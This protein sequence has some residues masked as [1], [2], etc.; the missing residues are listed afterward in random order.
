MSHQTGYGGHRGSQNPQ[1]RY[2]DD[3]APPSGPNTILRQYIMNQY[4]PSENHSGNPRNPIAGV[5]V[6]TLNDL[7]GPSVAPFPHSTVYGGRQYDQIETL[8][9][10]NDTATDGARSMYF[11]GPSRPTARSRLGAKN[12]NGTSKRKASNSEAGQSYD[13]MSPDNKYYP[14]LNCPLYEPL[15]NPITGKPLGQSSMDHCS[16]AE[17]GSRFATTY[18]QHDPMRYWHLRDVAEKMPT[19][20]KEK[21]ENYQKQLPLPLHNSKPRHPRHQNDDLFEEDEAEE[22]EEEEEEVK[23]AIKAPRRSKKVKTERYEEQPEQVEQGAHLRKGHIN[24][25]KNYR[26][27]FPDVPEDEIPPPLPTSRAIIFALLH[28]GGPLPG[29]KGPNDFG[30]RIIRLIQQCESPDFRN[31]MVKKLGIIRVHGVSSMQPDTAQ[32]Q[33]MELHGIHNASSTWSD[34]RQPDYGNVQDC[35]PDQPVQTTRPPQNDSPVPI[36]N[37]YYFDHPLSLHAPSNLSTEG[38]PT[39][40]HPGIGDLHGVGGS[41][42]MDADFNSILDPEFFPYPLSLTEIKF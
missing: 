1:A 8:S 5:P 27:N 11:P 15:K 29:G 3:A 33:T 6:A 34:S 32:P 42:A 20:A 18:F 30:A 9:S 22:E 7:P 25:I 36:A 21:E 26:K 4:A 16:D 19:K 38:G 41:G 40:L 12:L 2:P 37:N 10:I 17:I 28:A 24:W 23:L 14:L 35:G 13:N 39:W 31:E